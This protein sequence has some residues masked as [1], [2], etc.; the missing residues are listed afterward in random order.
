[1][2]LSIKGII[3]LA[4]CAV[5][6]LAA[7]FGL[8]RELSFRL[9]KNSADAIGTLVLRKKT[10]VRKYAE[11]VIW[12]DITN[13]TPVFNYDSIRTYPESAAF[14]KL[15]DGS[16]ISL[17]ESTMIV[18]VMDNDGVKI[19]FDQGSVA[20]KSG[21]T[22]SSIRL[23]TRD[24]SVSMNRGELTV[25][26]DSGIMNVNVFSG[27]AV[28]TAAGGD[29]KIDM[30]SAAKIT[31]DRVEIKKKS[32]ITEQPDNNA[33][34]IS[35]ANTA[36]VNF[37]WNIDS[38]NRS[39]I[40]IASDS[41]FKK[42]VHTKTVTA[43]SYTCRLSRGDYYWRI[44]S[45][46][47]SSAVKKITIL[48]DSVHRHL[49]PV[50][51]EK[52]SVIETD[53][54]NFR[55]SSSY[56]DAVYE[57]EIFSD[58]EMKNLLYRK[59]LSVNSLSLNTLPAGNLWWKVR[60]IYPGGFI[61][62]DPSSGPVGFKLEKK[63]LSRM[64]PVPIHNGGI[65]ATTISENIPLSWEQVRGA[66]A[67]IVEISR[68]KEFKEIIN[69]SETNTT[70]V[71]IKPLPQGEY[72]WRVKAV[73]DKDDFEISPIVPLIVGMPEPVEY[74]TPLKDAVLE[75]SSSIIRLAW[76]KSIDASRYLVEV[77]DSSD[78]KKIISTGRT[79]A[80]EFSFSNP[81]D[82]RYYWRVSILDKYENLKVA[83]NTSSFAIPATLEK[84]GQLLPPNQSR[85]NLD[86]INVLKFQWSAVKGADSYELEIFHNISGID[87]PLLSMTT[88]STK[89]ELRN[90]RS[91]EPGTLVW[92]V[93]ARKKSGNRITALS[94]SDR[95][96]F[97]LKVSENISAPRT[98]TREKYYVR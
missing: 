83:G 56:A 34:F 53:P 59:N 3:L 81:G 87:R 97:V 60:R 67:Y 40:Q 23:N 52:L 61:Y 13:N 14:I 31:D 90:F 46:N 38:G 42:I 63:A 93:R 39:V 75:N 37:K 1:M 5:L 88:Q 11:Y 41:E 29:K 15:N 55:W 12:E 32:I 45:G 71:R 85:I 57:F 50:Q 28:L 18:L 20:A 51:G 2:R 22:G 30:N 44:I 21:K 77:A 47:D 73:Y 95:M 6:I 65:Y 91:L 54:V 4:A 68:S 36:S 82:G 80:G 58:P 92:V 62:L 89:I 25:K 26:K 43:K 76:K 19:N 98:D 49:Y 86:D 17:D 33:R 69:T 64:K 7:S 74:I 79:D 35:A 16:E 96:Y 8:Y 70:F 27:D 84:P 66:S 48:N 94:E 10:A 24:S 78:F 9:Q 72:F